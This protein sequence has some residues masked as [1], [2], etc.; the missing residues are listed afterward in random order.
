MQIWQMP[1]L[2]IE[3]DF[4]YDY[5]HVKKIIID[6]GFSLIYNRDTA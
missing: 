4:F 2:H 1:I 5:Y 3:G 6:G